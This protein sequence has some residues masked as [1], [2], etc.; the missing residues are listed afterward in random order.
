METLTL[1]E[2][3]ALPITP[4]RVKGQRALSDKHAAALERLEKNLPRGAFSWRHHAVKFAQYCGVITL[5]G[6]M[7]EILPKIHGKEAEPGACREALIKMLATAGRLKPQKAAAGAVAL[8]KHSLLDVF[9]LHFCDQL[10]TQLM[11]GMIRRYVERNENITVLRGRLRVER[12]FKYNLAHEARLF[13]QYDELSADNPHNQVIKRVLRLMMRA[14]VGPSAGKRLSE[15]LMRFDAISDVEADLLMIDSLTFD[16]ATNRYKP[17][18]DLCRWFTRGL[19]PDVLAGRNDCL[20]LLFD[21]NRLFESYAAH[22]FKKRAWRNELGLQRERPRKYMALRE[23]RSQ[24]LFLMK[25]DMVFLTR[26]NEFAAIADA[27]W[28][29]LDSG[30]KNLGV[31][32]ADLYQMAAYAGRYGVRRLALVYP[33]QQGLQK[34]VTLRL[35]TSNAILRV[36]PLDVAAKP[37]ASA[38]GGAEIELLR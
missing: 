20:T 5:G 11:Q 19:Y 23:D 21:M 15:L 36:I 9:I 38:M 26:N 33:R 2:H 13:C 24:D 27:K 6:L 3:E 22:V 14:P 35:K 8:Q 34:A 1:I 16:R 37:E 10:H 32:Q 29:I 31:S 4:T 18:I 7:L 30:K 28:K 25:P 12:Q 17:I